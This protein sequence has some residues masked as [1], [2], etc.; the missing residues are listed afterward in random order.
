MTIVQACR[1]YSSFLFGFFF[2]T[3]LNSS[4]LSDAAQTTSRLKQTSVSSSRTIRE[5]EHHADE[6]ISYEEMIQLQE[7]W[8]QKEAKSGYSHDQY[9][10]GRFYHQ[11]GNLKQAKHFL[12]LAAR[13]GYPDAQRDL[14]LIYYE[15]GYPEEAERYLKHAADQGDSE[16]QY[17]L[18][19]FLELVA[20]KGNKKAQEEL[21]LLELELYNK[22]NDNKALLNWLLKPLSA[23][24]GSAM[25]I[26][27]L[28]CIDRKVIPV[29]LAVIAALAYQVCRQDS[30]FASTTQASSET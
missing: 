18:G 14:G 12:K 23:T 11:Q 26:A 21:Q 2:L 6:P 29:V 25:I 8:L 13:Q 10:L 7:K 5:L 30:R 1:V 20:R 27:L 15:Q 24:V 9:Q 28:A 22:H 3:I 4:T 19:P 16:A 17:V